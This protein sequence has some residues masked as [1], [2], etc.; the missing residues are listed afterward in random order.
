[1]RI[2]MQPFLK[3][4]YCFRKSQSRLLID[5]LL[6]NFKVYGP[7]QLQSPSHQMK[8]VAKRFTKT[9]VVF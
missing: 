8:T 7:L 2:I 5:P 6:Q 1:M 9:V 3:H 4:Y